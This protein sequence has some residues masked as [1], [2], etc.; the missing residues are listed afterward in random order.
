[1]VKSPHPID[2]IATRISRANGGGVRLTHESAGQNGSRSD[3][4]PSPSEATVAALSQPIDFPPLAAGI[5]PG[6]RVAIAID[7]SIPCVGEIA[8]G[9][10]RAL[11]SADVEHECISVV[12]CDGATNKICRE[13]CTAE[14]ASGVK[15]VVHD[16]DDAE[17]LCMV[18]VSKRRKEPLLVNRTIFDAD[19]V[20][21]IGCARVNGRGAYE[22]LFPRF[23]SADAIRRYRT[24]TN[25]DSPAEQEARTRETD[26]AGWL[27][28]VQMV[29]E[30][31][32]GS[33]E[34]VAH[35][36]AGEPTAVAEKS[37]ELSRERWILESPQQVNLVIATVTGGP[38]S[39]TWAN[40]GRALATAEPLTTE[41][42]A[43]AICSNLNE[44]PGHSLGRLIGNP[45]LEAAERKISHDQDADSWAAWQLAKAL[46][47]G[48][49]YF[50]SQ[51]DAETVEDMGLAPIE[52]ID[53][54]VRLAARQH[55]FVL[56]ED[57]QNA[58]I[59]LAGNGDEQ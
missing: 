12:S 39:Q 28:G 48:P 56:V 5:V 1:L 41:N 24:P 19:V 30:V 17:N 23:S 11:E 40:V 3:H 59:R 18:G 15:F 2:E 9:A 6:D 45:D 16:P 51:L 20:L 43:V 50:L 29:V 53:E 8:R 58:V 44:P 26:E 37:A 35:V 32:P 4:V 33:G 34:S 31:I 13:A 21:P 42:G 52:D 49:V 54:L 22:S 7:E 46:Q 57:S 27:I 10:I 55:N 36:L 25:L 14:E 38:E 47:R